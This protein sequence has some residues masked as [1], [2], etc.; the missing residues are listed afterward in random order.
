LPDTLFTN[1]ST[2]EANQL[3]GKDKLKI[4]IAFISTPFIALV[5]AQVVRSG[6][7]RIMNTFTTFIFEDEFGSSE[8][9]AAGIM[10]IVLGCGGIAAL[11]SGF[12]SRRHGS[13]KIF[14]WSV[15]GT[16]IAGTVVSLFVGLFKYNDWQA[17]LPLLILAVLFF[18]FLSSSSKHWLFPK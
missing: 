2:G 17:T 9:A 8:F 4:K 16:I 18:I 15:I 7:F 12:I 3:S 11:I 6:I 14:L 1:H 13:L 10:S 5:F